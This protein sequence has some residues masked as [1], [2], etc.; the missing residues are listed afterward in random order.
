MAH[1]GVFC[2]SAPGHLNPL[3]CLGREL[4]S[5]GHRVTTFQPLEL[6]AFVR[7]SGLEFQPIGVKAFPPGTVSAAYA[8]MGALKGLAALR[9]LLSF[10]IRKSEM[11]MTEGPD[12]VRRAGIDLLLVDQVE[13]DAACVADH[14]R[15]PFITVSNAL[16]PNQE[17]AIPPIF[18]GWAYSTGAFALLRNRLAYNFQAR[19]VKDWEVML[20]R[21][22]QIWGLPVYGTLLESTSPWA[23]LSQQPA[24]FDFP[25]RLLP[26]QFHY[27]GPWQDRRSRPPEPF[28]YEKLSGKPLI[29]ASMGTLQ[30]RIQQVFREIA[31]ACDGL[32]TQLVVSLG[33]GSTPEQV[34]ALPGNPIVVGYAPQ[35]ELLTRA[36][37]TITHAGLNTALESLSHG[38]PMVA[39]PVGNDQPGVASRVKW[40]G[41][42]Q[43]VPVKRLSAA[44]LRPLVKEVLTQPRYKQRAVQLQKEIQAADGIRRAAGVIE[45]VLTEQRPVLRAAMPA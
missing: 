5:R 26:P 7:R 22:R 18:T 39:I 35:L 1:I 17:P 13:I 21:Q 32:D 33:G 42:G 31:L 37:L 30:N 19:L 25:R 6:E 28:P 16:I 15:I 44:R 41:V 34:G 9:F 38:V 11:L 3:S 29:Y 14:L 12:V 40:L 24:C 10:W 43:V 45:Q 36:A 8:R 2:P 4:Q 20:N 23:H 27:T